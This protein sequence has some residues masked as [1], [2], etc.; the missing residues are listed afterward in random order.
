MPRIENTKTEIY[1]KCLFYKT[2]CN[3]I[4]QFFSSHAFALYHDVV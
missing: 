4:R 1:I 2:K 3:Q